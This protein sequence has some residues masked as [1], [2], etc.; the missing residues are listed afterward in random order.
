MSDSRP[1]KQDSS[2]FMLIF[3]F[4]LTFMI[5][6][7]QDLR[8]LLGVT[9]G[10]VLYPILGFGSRWPILTILFAGLV[11]TLVSVLIRH[12]F[13]DWVGMAKN[14]K[15]MGAFNKELRE[16]RLA[17]DQQRMDKLLKIQK[18]LMQDQ[19][20]QS[21]NQMK[22]MVFS[23]LIIISIF[24]WIY[25]FLD[26]LGN[27]TFSIPWASNIHLLRGGPLWQIM[28]VWILIYSLV[29]I[30]LGQVI[31]KALKEYTF[32]KR[33]AKMEQDAFLPKEPSEDTGSAVEE[34]EEHE[35]DGLE[36][37]EEDYLDE[38]EE[39]SDEDGEDEDESPSDLTV[40][41]LAP[42]YIEPGTTGE[43][44]VRLGN[45][46]EQ[47]IKDVSFDFSNLAEFFDVQGEVNISS[48]SPGMEL[49]KPIRI[50]PKYN[51]GSFPVNVVITAD[52]ITVEKRCNIKVGGTE[53]FGG[54]EEDDN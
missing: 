47:T 48:L 28:P 18:V 53:V 17:G 7:N 29:S 34:E 20:A 50:R 39:E 1:P 32:N 27:K 51:K 9:V 4:M 2:S 11:M 44:L 26:G 52:G 14:Q 19:M 25:I 37:D 23:M 5:M 15:V 6:F 38:D 46:T 8:M 49:E 41:L 10:A 42:S 45:K 35:E 22:P 43:L 36:E 21:S 3:V 54:E 31:Q 16:A 24:T 40:S 13:M 12:K 33:L 30:P